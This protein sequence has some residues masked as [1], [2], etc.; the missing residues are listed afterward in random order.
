VSLQG[1]SAL[2][3]RLRAIRQTPKGIVRKWA[4]ADVRESRKRIKKR[5]GETAASVH[6]ARVTDTH[7]EIL[8][9]EVINFLV[10][11]TKAH[12]E[13]AH[14]RA[15]KFQA[16]GKTMFAPKVHKRATRG[17]GLKMKAAEE[18]LKQ[19]P[20]AAELIKQWNDAA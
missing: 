5:T 6:V 9:S 2:D 4:D 18:A 7:A 17:N 19:T 1:K 13:V 15:M 10:A 3:S 16:R 8:G 11:G 14:G 20:M 12:D